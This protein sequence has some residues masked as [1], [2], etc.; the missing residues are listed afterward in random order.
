MNEAKIRLSPEEMELVIRPDWILTKN[1]VMRKAKE[2]FELLAS[3]QQAIIEIHSS[4]LP[5]EVIAVPPKISKGENYR[6][7][8]YLVLDYPRFFNRENVF[9]I[10]TLFWWGN[11]FSSTLHL[12]GK[13]KQLLESRILASYS[14]LG[15][16]SISVGEN[17]WEHHFDKDNYQLIAETK[18][19]DFK[20]SV[21]EKSF[22]KLAYR[23]QLQQ[24]DNALSL[25]EDHFNS[26]L[27]LLAD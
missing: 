25:L 7:L 20:K 21:S 24:W 26:W 3:R 4:Q 19:M 14:S 5:L 2:L 16:C 6:G 22:L 17:E 15:D 18:E 12:S 10:R 11:F 1:A 8:P 13:Y 23:V 9:A 27:K